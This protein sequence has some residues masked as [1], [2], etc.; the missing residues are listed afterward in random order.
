MS[1]LDKKRIVDIV[2]C[3]YVHASVLYYFGIEFYNY[4]NLTLEQACKAKGLKIE[5]VVK[6]LESSTYCEEEV[7]W[8]GFPIDLVIEYLKHAH[9]IFIKQK[10]P[11]I[12]KLIQSLEISNVTFSSVIKD[13]KFVF[14]LF[15][16]DFIHHI[17]EEEDTL[18]TYLLGLHGH[19]KGKGNHSKLYFEMENNSLSKYASE[20]QEHDDEMMGIR[21]ITK[22][23]QLDGSAPLHLRVIYSEL[24]ALEYDLKKHAKVENDI[25]FPKAL[26][27]EK[28]VKNSFKEKIQLN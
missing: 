24:Q 12:S 15:L 5:A 16:E 20:H 1:T 17:Y 22:Q 23:Y 18:F 8:H 10:L 19:L 3:N 21:Q 4:S 9:Y 11:Y 13:L 7:D 2:D 6:K 26:M 27:L 14:P 25:L 28:Q